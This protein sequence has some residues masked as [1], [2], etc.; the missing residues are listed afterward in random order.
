MQHIQTKTMREAEIRTQELLICNMTLHQ[1]RYRV[2]FHVTRCRHLST[3]LQENTSELSSWIS[4]SQSLP[5]TAVH[6]WFSVIRAKLKPQVRLV[7]VY[8]NKKNKKKKKNKKNKKNRV[9]LPLYTIK[10]Q[11]KVIRLFPIQKLSIIDLLRTVLTVS[12]YVITWLL[13]TR[14]VL[15][16]VANA[17]VAVQCW[18]WIGTCPVSLR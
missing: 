11:H 4:L 9:I 8:N 16:C 6:N 15:H 1:W 18:W 5:F 17:V 13:M 10:R 2:E 12:C 7:S 3:S 14:I